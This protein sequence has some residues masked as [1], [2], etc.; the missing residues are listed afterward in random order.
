[1]N[2]K[3]KVIN[4]FI[5]GIIVLIIFSSLYFIVDKLNNKMYVSVTMKQSLN[6]NVE[7]YYRD[8]L[9]S[10]FSGHTV[11]EI[12]NKR[13]SS[14]NFERF[15]YIVPENHLNNLT[16]RTFGDASEKEINYVDIEKID[17]YTMFNHKRLEEF[18]DYSYEVNGRL[19][20]TTLYEGFIFDKWDLVGKVKLYCMIIS[21][22]IV[23]MWSKKIDK[24]FY[25]EDKTFYKEKFVSIV[26]ATSLISIF[27]I[28][29]L[30]LDDEY[31]YIDRSRTV[32]KPEVE[33]YRRILSGD[34]FSEY[35]EYIKSN[36]FY[37]PFILEDYYAFNRLMG[38]EYFGNNYLKKYVTKDENGTYIGFA[39]D[40]D[41]NRV[42]NNAKN[43]VELKEFVNSKG[44][45]FQY[46]FVPNKDS[47][48]FEHIPSYLSTEEKSGAYH[49]E[50]FSVLEDGGVNAVNMYYPIK[51]ELTEKG[52]QTH[53]ALDTHWNFE[54]AFF[55]YTK[56]LENLED[57]GI[58]NSEDITNKDDFN[59]TN[60]ENL[61]SGITGRFLGYGYRYDQELDD[62]VIITPKEDIKVGFN[63]SSTNLKE[64]TGKYSSFID[65]KILNS[66]NKY[67]YTYTVYPHNPNFTLTN[68]NKKDGKNALFIRDSFGASISW[69]LINNFSSITVIDPRFMEEGYILELIEENKYDVVIGLSYFGSN[70]KD[71]LFDYFK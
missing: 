59:F 36:F 44:I 24:Y 37:R 12:K 61:Y 30:T 60:Y 55:A 5:K 38:I 1:M 28:N 22:A 9:G 71:D 19:D 54:T 45:P 2:I 64:V 70:D 33:N 41:S 46:Y 53:F 23:A 67:E 15:L 16:L 29:T 32:E 50:F 10:P 18:D 58:L 47:L 42:T 27:L 14:E 11:S 3:G 48:N 66:L 65:K 17:I 13:N 7:L 40:Y 57:N 56:I 34:Y 25:K 20:Y 52:V 35:V 31:S 68:Y 63:S 4:I 39:V 49:E 62:I 21:I 69:F 26:F 43:I 51:E 8:Y 6:K